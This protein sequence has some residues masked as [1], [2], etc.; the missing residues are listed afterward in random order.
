MKVH[1]KGREA[2][3]KES[4]LGERK[5]RN[6]FEVVRRISRLPF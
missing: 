4:K 2:N 5:V 1:G 3:K 6:G